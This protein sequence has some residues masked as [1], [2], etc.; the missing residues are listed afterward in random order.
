VQALSRRCNEPTDVV[1]Y[2][3]D[4]GF[5]RVISPTFTRTSP[6]LTS[7]PNKHYVPEAVTSETTFGL[8]F[9]ENV[10]VLVSAGDIITELD[11]LTI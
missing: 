6:I 3:F 1:T 5:T 9:G 2:I 8:N 11:V 4:S 10:N 7:I